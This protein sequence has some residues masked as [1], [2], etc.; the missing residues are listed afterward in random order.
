MMERAIVRSFYIPGTLSANHS[1]GYEFPFPTRL[2]A[3][4]VWASNDS[5]A[6]LA[7][8]DPSV[9]LVTATTIGDSGDPKTINPD[10]AEVAQTAQDTKV[11][12]TLDFDGDGGTA[13]QNVEIIVILKTGEGGT[14][15]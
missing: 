14:V 15:N 7:V 6:T 12:L 2:E 8:A 4:K 1:V 5:D 9:T 10:G 13:A 3:I 11:T